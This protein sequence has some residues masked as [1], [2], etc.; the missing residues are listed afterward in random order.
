M[1]GIRA[2]EVIKSQRVVSAAE[3]REMVGLSDSQ[4]IILLL[5][6]DD[7]ILERLFDPRLLLEL[8]KAGYNLIVSPSFSAWEPRPRME[9]MYNAK[10]SLVIYQTLQELGVPALPRVV[11]STNQ[12]AERWAEWLNKNPY[13]ADI[14]ID[15]MTYR[16]KD[17]WRRLIEGLQLVDELTAHR[18]R[19]LVNGPTTEDRFMELACAVPFE[20]LHITNAL[21]M[22]AP[23]TQEE[24]K[25][26]SAVP[27]DKSGVRFAAR[28]NAQRM[29]LSKAY[30][31]SHYIN[32][33]LAG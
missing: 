9:I 32:Q 24:S 3:V 21:V 22:A 27:G 4:E 19:Y 18:L 17:G 29:R 6:D 11:W 2:G 5:F 12:D 25:L 7:P 23:P 13:A 28:V 14:A 1:Y 33:P 31:G 16:G 8:S 30:A 26:F 20:R 10:R 15:S